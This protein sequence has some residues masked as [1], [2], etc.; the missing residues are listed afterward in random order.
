VTGEILGVLLLPVAVWLLLYY[1]RVAD[2][3]IRCWCHFRAELAR[4]QK[5]EARR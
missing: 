5:Q 4:H 3:C 2:V 1:V